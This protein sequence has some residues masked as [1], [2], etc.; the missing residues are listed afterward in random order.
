MTLAVAGAGLA[1]APAQ[2]HPSDEILQQVYLTPTRA[3]LD[4]ELD[5]TPGVLVAPAFARTVDTDGDG[6][7]SDRETAAHLDRVASALHLRV[8]GSPVALTVTDSSYPPRELL[9]AAGGTA[10]V[11]LSAGLPQGGQHVTFTDA[12]DPGGRTTVQASLMV[13]AKDATST[14]AAE[15]TDGGRSISFRVGGGETSATAQGPPSRTQSGAR[16]TPSESEAGGGRLLAALRTPL[17][18]PWA[19]LALIGTC[20]LLG[21]FHALTPGHG[22]ALLASYLVGSRSTP[23]QAVA[24]GA[25][26]TVTHTSSVIVLG[27][28]ALLA[29]RYVMP[30]T[31]VPALEAASGTV[32]V[33]LGA[34]LLLRRRRSRNVHDHPHDHHHPLPH[35]SDHPHAH[36]RREWPSS[37]RGIAAL[38]VSGGI[39]PCPEALGVLLLAVGLHRTALGLTMIVAFSVGLAGVLVALGLLLVT[40]RTTLTRFRHA[41]PGL[42]VRTLP[43]CSA[44]FVT[45][46]GLTIALHGMSGLA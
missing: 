39:I 6:R 15:R 46:L 43:M 1:A 12:Y 38:G 8:D 30:G 18:S 26:I 3:R 11:R 41:P 5:V 19:L 21:A 16:R 28:L 10:V 34:R 45:A 33:L 27:T 24:L 44:V 31:L 9:A 4:I 17:S 37:F 36:A 13:A 29:G 40:A 20:A 25:V 2:A 42:L 23:R 14:G 35:H 22:K 32:V 7:F